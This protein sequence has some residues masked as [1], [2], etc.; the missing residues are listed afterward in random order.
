MLATWLSADSVWSAP[1]HATYMRTSN[2]SPSPTQP[3]PPALKRRDYPSEVARWAA[4]VEEADGYVVVTAEYNHGYPALLKNALDHAFPE[5][6]RKPVAFVG[7]GNVGGARAIEQ[8]RL[9]SVEFEMAPVRWAVHILPDAMRPIR[10]AEGP[11]D[12]ELFASLDERLETLVADLLW[13]A[14]ALARARENSRPTA[15]TP[16]V[17]RGDGRR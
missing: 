8:L 11:L 2:G 16:I 10:L 13:W 4:K 1:N 15:R 7:Y 5:F 3:V 12:V 14:A 6:N 9:V 17:L